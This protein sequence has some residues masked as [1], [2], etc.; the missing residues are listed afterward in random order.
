MTRT[1][2]FYG[3]CFDYAEFAYWDIKSNENLYVR[4]G[5]RTGLFFLPEIIQ[6]QTLLNFLFRLQMQTRQNFKMEFLS[7]LTETQATKM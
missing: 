4:N 7:E 2:T 5:M 1:T 3:V 6:I